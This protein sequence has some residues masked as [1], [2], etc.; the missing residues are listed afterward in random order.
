MRAKKGESL[1]LEVI[2]VAILVLLV[3]IVLFMV[4]TGRMHFFQ[5]GLKTCDGVCSTIDDCGKG[6]AA[7]PID[8][9]GNMG[10]SYS[11]CCVEVVKEEK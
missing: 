8:N 4:F 10:K 11:Y 6:K 2:V 5:Q 3:L 7:I 9:C 1:S